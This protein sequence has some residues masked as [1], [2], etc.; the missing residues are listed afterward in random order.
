MHNFTEKSTGLRLEII[1][2]IKDFLKEANRNFVI[3]KGR[4]TYLCWDCSQPPT[5]S[6]MVSL[7]PE[8]ELTM[9]GLDENGDLLFTDTTG[10][11]VYQGNLDTEELV[12]VADFVDELKE[13]ADRQLSYGE[14]YELNREFDDA[15][16]VDEDCEDDWS[17][18]GLGAN[19]RLAYIEERR[20][21]AI[22]GPEEFDCPDKWRKS[23]KS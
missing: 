16:V 18:K 21:G 13:G 6:D 4:L 11:W 17:D 1:G 14:L 7:V 3:P 15:F 22:S 9:M 20:T 10:E 12:Y 8:M 5:E 2:Y 23:T 19:A